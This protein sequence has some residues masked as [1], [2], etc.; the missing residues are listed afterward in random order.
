MQKREKTKQRTNPRS[1][2][3][4]KSH[5]KIGGFISIHLTEDRFEGCW[6]TENRYVNCRLD[7]TREVEGRRGFRFKAGPR[8]AGSD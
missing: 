4:E 8:T 2:T 1:T 5:K 7:M 6:E 3:S